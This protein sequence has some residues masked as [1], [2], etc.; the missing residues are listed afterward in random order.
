MFL[1][2]PRPIA[3]TLFLSKYSRP[4]R[5]FRR[6]EA[7]VANRTMTGLSQLLFTTGYLGVKAE[8]LVGRHI[9]GELGHDLSDLLGKQQG[10]RKLGNSVARIPV[11]L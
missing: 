2:A 3:I 6:V 5:A 7:C 9:V 11:H 8:R 4:A 1:L 10:N